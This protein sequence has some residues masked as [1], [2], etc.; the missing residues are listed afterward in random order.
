MIVLDTS[1]ILA[2]FL[3]EPGKAA[4]ERDAQA[5][6]ISATVLT[7][8]MGRIIR[9]GLVAS[10]LIRMVEGYNIAI[11]PF[12]RIQAE[13]AGELIVPGREHG[14]GLGDCCV[15]ALA[16]SR[17]SPILTGDREWLNLQAIVLI[18]IRIFR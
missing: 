6:C 5:A 11:I 2:M 12:D 3:N 13:I 18:E 17:R 15:L 1:A 9:G 4:V 7:E 10:P 8:A 16:I 14:V